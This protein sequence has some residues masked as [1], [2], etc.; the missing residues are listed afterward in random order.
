MR[1]LYPAVWMASL[2]LMTMLSFTA[3]AQTNAVF[4]AGKATHLFVIAAGNADVTQ[5]GN[6]FLL[7]LNDVNARTMYFTN[8]S[9]ADASVMPTQNFIS[10]WIQADNSFPKSP[11]Q[12]VIVFNDMLVDSDG[13]NHGVTV[14]L[15]NP[16]VLDDYTWQF[17]MKD[18][19]GKVM[20]GDFNETVMYVDKAP[21]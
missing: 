13:V 21:S 11:Q 20:I 12:V 4:N 10:S 7:T 6:N 17:D 18:L 5:S 1:K 2:L 9:G 8:Q 14:E 16:K 3:S 15:S 19:S